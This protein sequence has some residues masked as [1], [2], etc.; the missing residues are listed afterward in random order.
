MAFGSKA[1]SLQ[2]L[3]KNLARGKGGFIKRIT[4]DGVIVRFLQEPENWLNYAEH[5]DGESYVLCSNQDDCEGCLERHKKT[6]RYLAPAID[7]TDNNRVVS[8]KLPVTLTNQLVNRYEKWGTVTDRDYELSSSGSG[9]DTTYVVDY[10]PP[11]KMNLAKYD[12]PDLEEVLERAWEDS[13][14]RTLDEVKVPK[15]TKKPKTR[16]PVAASKETK[17]KKKKPKTKGVVSSP[18]VVEKSKAKAASKLAD[19]PKKKDSQKKATPPPEPDFSAPDDDDDDD[20]YTE[21][22]LKKMALGGLRAVAN[23]FGIDPKGLNKSQLV[24]AIMDSGDP[25]EEDKPPF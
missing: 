20:T 14:G 13:T 11:T 6:H 21:A 12:V 23:S 25:V 3:K 22:D 5:Y 18:A 17:P 8:L 9:K 16:G 4:P 1:G 10:Q 15:V 2:K 7:R 19:A 24:A